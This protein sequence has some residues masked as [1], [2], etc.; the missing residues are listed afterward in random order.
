MGWGV[1]PF[2]FCEIHLFLIFIEKKLFY[3][4][5][6]QKKKKKNPLVIV[7]K[8]GARDHITEICYL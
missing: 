8:L 7:V 3:V 2:H 4:C 6:W 5:H 1:V